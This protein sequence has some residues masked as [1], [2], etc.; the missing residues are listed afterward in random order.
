MSYT[1]PKKPKPISLWRKP[2][3]PSARARRRLTNLR[4]RDRTDK[5][6]TEAIDRKLKVR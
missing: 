1:R 4:T 5:R 2:K 6:A 3:P